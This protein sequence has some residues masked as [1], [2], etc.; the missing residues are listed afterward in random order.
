MLT[1]F[2]MGA[3]GHMIENCRAFKH[4]VQDLIESKAITFAPNGPNINNNPMSSHVGPSVSVIEEEK[5][6][7]RCV[8]DI[9]TPLA[10]VKEQ[11]LMNEVH[12]KCDAKCEDCLMNPQGCEKLKVSI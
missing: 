12:P 10:V 2:H 11:L 7:K 4:K 6:V 1:E 5:M 9:R 8:G 3:P